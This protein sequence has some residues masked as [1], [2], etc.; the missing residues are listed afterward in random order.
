M[1]SL[2]T[3]WLFLLFPFFVSAQMV[4]GT[5][6]LFG[7]EWI[8]YD[9]VYFKIPVAEDGLVRILGSELGAAGIPINSINANQF[10]VFHL[11]KEIPI[12]VSGA[13]TLADTDYIT[14]AGK[15]NRAE[16]DQFLFPESGV[17]LHPNYSLFT[18]TSAY[19]LTWNSNETGL[20]YTTINNDILNPPSPT[21]F[22][23]RTIEK[24]FQDYWAKKEYGSGTKFSHFDVAEGFS[25]SLKTKQDHSFSP[26][27]PY[28]NGINATIEVNYASRGADHHQEIRVNNNLVATDEYSG[29]QVRHLSFDVPAA[30]LSNSISFKMKGLANAENKIDRSRIGLLQLTYPQQFDFEGKSQYVFELEANAQYIEIADVDLSQGIPI[31]YDFA[32]QQRLEGKIK[33]NLVVFMLPQTAGKKELILSAGDNGIDGTNVK[34]VNFIDYAFANSDYLMIANTRLMDDGN[35]HN[36]VQDYA[37][38]RASTVG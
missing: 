22:F 17:R 36:Y 11:G 24:N 4:V 23:W 16:L 7:N 15:K 20:R 35:G 31:L 33:N 27:N 26:I 28:L 19:F 9:Q 12:Y 32:N 1:R 21:P 6:T 10:Q 29:W 2:L 38:Y 25:T 14:F 18:D 5:D 37:D 13:G 3:L 34:P 8:Q 30:E